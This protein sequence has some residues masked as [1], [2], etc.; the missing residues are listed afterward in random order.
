M[1]SLAR[2]VIAICF[3]ALFF[4]VTLAAAESPTALSGPVLWTTADALMPAWGFYPNGQTYGDTKPL[5]RWAA[6]TAAEYLCGLRPGQLD[7]TR[8]E[9][10]EA[11]MVVQTESGAAK[12][13]TSNR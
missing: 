1:R 8:R 10:A 4:S 12:G 2:N 3:A 5:G 9:L 6:W 13:G 11:T 7:R